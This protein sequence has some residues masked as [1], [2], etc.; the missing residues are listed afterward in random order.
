MFQYVISFFYMT[1]QTM[2]RSAISRCLSMGPFGVVALIS[3]IASL[4][5]SQSWDNKIHNQ[6]V[7][8]IA[9]WSHFWDWHFCYM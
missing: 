6:S 2:R 5:S 9:F 1:P 4:F 3:Q 7:L 8:D